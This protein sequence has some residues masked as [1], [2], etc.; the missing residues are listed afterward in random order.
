MDTFDSS[1]GV[2]Y[3]SRIDMSENQDW[4]PVKIRVSKEKN[5]GV[6]STPRIRYS[7]VASDLHKLESVET[8]KPRML[9]TQSRL[10]MA[11]ARTAKGL[12]QKQLDM[13]CAFPSNTSN[14]I[15]SGRL[16]PS[17]VHL[18]NLH[19]VLKIKLEYE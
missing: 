17:R 7:T 13:T 14:A 9:T 5:Q 19:R 18:N 16:C 15:E 3:V 2:F 8:G 12:T 1:K 10:D 6:S 4:V 11:L